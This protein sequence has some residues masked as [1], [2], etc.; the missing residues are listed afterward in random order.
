MTVLAFSRPFWPLFLHVLGA[1][2]LWGAILAALVVAIARLPRATLA[3]LFVAV[4]AW[5]LTLG[6][7]FWIESKEGFGDSSPTWLGIGHG[8]LEPG[9]VVL[10]AAIG[11][12]YWWARSGKPLAGRITAGLAALY[13]VL[14]TIALLAMSGKWS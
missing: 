3:S 9:V 8:V 10:L 7:G 14:L 12:A 4:P 2:V 5:A 6:G 1:M 13:L 11:S